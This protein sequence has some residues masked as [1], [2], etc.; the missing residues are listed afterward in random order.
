MA[1]A[2]SSNLVIIIYLDARIDDL[3][4]LLCT[5]M[6]L[7]LIIKLRL[8]KMEG[9]FFLDTSVINIKTHTHCC[10]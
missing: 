7:N 5:G 4:E 2:L 8:V 3:V 6:M 1:Y 10:T 9:I